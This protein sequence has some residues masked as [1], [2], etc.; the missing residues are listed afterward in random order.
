M[1]KA[2]PTSSKI[3]IVKMGDLF[4]ISQPLLKHSSQCVDW[5]L[6]MGSSGSVWPVSLM[7]FGVR[8]LIVRPPTQLHSSVQQFG[9]PV[10]LPMLTLPQPSLDNPSFL[11]LHFIILSLKLHS[12]KSKFRLFIE[13]SLGRSMAFRAS[14]PVK[15]FPNIKQPRLLG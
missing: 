4:F 3:S 10:S 8:R 13:M 11:S 14:A 1:Q 15:L 5:A 12:R 9:R 6:V 7:I 2:R